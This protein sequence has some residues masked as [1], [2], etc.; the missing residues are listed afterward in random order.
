MARPLIDVFSITIFPESLPC[1]IH[2]SISAYDKLDPDFETYELYE[3]DAEHADLIS[4]NGQALLVTDLDTVLLMQK[5]V[6]T[7][8]LKDRDKDD[9]LIASGVVE[10]DDATSNDYE[11][12]KHL[13]VKGSCGHV[14]VN[15][16]ALSCAVVADISVLLLERLG[17][18]FVRGQVDSDTGSIPVFGSIVVH[19]GKTFGRTEHLSI[20]LLNTSSNQSTP[21]I[22]DSEKAYMEL[23][24]NLVAVPIYSSLIVKTIFTETNSN[25][26]F[27]NESAEVWPASAERAWSKLGYA[28]RR[29]CAIDYERHARIC[30][31]WLEPFRLQPSAHKLRDSVH[32][33]QG[34]ILLEVFSVS[35]GRENDNDLSVA[36]TNTIDLV[37]DDIV[38]FKRD[39]NDPERLLDGRKLL[40]IVNPYKPIEFMSECINVNMRIEL[41]DVNR[42]L[43]TVDGDAYFYTIYLLEE[44]VQQE[45]DRLL[46][47]AVE[48]EGGYCAIHYAVFKSAIR[49]KVNVYLLCKGVDVP[50]YHGRIVAWSDMFDYTREY[51]RKYYRRILFDKPDDDKD[52]LWNVASKKM[53]TDQIFSDK[54]KTKVKLSSSYVVVPVNCA[55]HIDLDLSV[56]SHRRGDPA[57]AQRLQDTLKFKV[58]GKSSIKI[59]EDFDLLIKVS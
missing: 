37:D 31:K 7:F 51:D 34:D 18:N 12:I 11:E 8:F 44:Y 26:T 1:A 17:S 52:S 13:E 23:T 5:P 47:S 39:K 53:K 2:G 30:L 16:V 21:I 33:C 43:L 10:L 56:S 27:I 6:I 42:G 38:I 14:T 19:Y 29:C 35:I 15:Y 50:E 58:G 55:L 40:S 36:G 48:G 32:D 45:F 4:E 46:C 28:N 9:A 49:M 59:G 24:R 54:P 57:S 41:T 20:T 3:H 25:Q 22:F